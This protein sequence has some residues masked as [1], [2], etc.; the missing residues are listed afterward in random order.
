MSGPQS[1]EPVVSRGWSSRTSA[2][3]S[4]NN[5]AGGG[6]PTLRRCERRPAT[7][8]LSTARSTTADEQKVSVFVQLTHRLAY[9][10]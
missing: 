3:R 5:T 6:A 8:A 1:P 10:S 4:G 7:T 9:A 2:G